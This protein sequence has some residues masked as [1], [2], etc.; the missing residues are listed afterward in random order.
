LEKLVIFT[1]QIKE[2]KFLN[3][4]IIENKKKEEVE[5]LITEHNAKGGEDCYYRLIEDKHTID[6]IVKVDK[7]GLI[8]QLVEI[9]N[10]IGVVSTNLYDLEKSL[11][12]IKDKIEL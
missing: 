9:E 3:Y 5:N 12:N 8:N 4:Q 1:I 10:S 6:A 2:D 7:E 11:K